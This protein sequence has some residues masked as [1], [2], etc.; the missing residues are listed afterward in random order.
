MHI[1]IK[2]RSRCSNLSVD[3]LYHNLS[4]KYDGVCITDHH[5]LRTIKEHL[6][7]GEKFMLFGVEIS[8]Q[9]GDIL[10]YGIEYYPHANKHLKAERVLQNIHNQG[11]VA[12]CAH[13]FTN[14]H[15]GF[16]EEVYNYEFDA[17]E[18][19]G[20]LEEDFHRTTE[21]AAKTM[22]IP[23]IGGSDAHSITQLNTVGTKFEIPITS[24]KDVVEAIKNKKCKPIRIDERVPYKFQ[25]RI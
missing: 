19:N 7:H 22:G 20:A 1:H 25:G 3:D 6:F 14:R 11:G 10:A 13:P 16:G 24:I 2:Y 23:L 4:D 8:C 9:R 15:T 17:L 18:I 21:D 5:K 12:V